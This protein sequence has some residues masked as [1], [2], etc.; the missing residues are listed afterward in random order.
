MAARHTTNKQGVINPPSE[1]PIRDRLVTTK[2]QW[3]RICGAQLDRTETAP[4]KTIDVLCTTMANLQINLYSCPSIYGA[5]LCR[6]FDASPNL[7]S[8]HGKPMVEVHG[9]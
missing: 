9:A 1:G 2:N 3:L 5:P 6:G 4:P 8:N 7:G